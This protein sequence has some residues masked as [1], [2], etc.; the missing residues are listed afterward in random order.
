MSVSS[1]SVTDDLSSVAVVAVALVL[2]GAFAMLLLELRQ[3]DAILREA[4]WVL[5]DPTR[6]AAYDRALTRS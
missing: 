2:A 1:W 6:R 3:R 4:W 5:R